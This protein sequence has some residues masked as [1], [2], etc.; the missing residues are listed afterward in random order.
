MKTED[1]PLILVACALL[2]IGMALDHYLP[3]F[4]VNI[5]MTCIAVVAVPVLVVWKWKAARH[6]RTH[7]G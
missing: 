6:A 5:A 2:W 1:P 3:A 4:W 7:A